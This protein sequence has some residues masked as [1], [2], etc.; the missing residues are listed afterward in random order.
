[1]RGVLG[2]PGDVEWLSIIAR[3]RD[4]AV[5]EQNELLDGCESIDERRVPV[6]VCRGEAIQHQKGSASANWTISDLNAIDRNAC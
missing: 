3:A 4:P 2:K 1:M 6:L 5:I